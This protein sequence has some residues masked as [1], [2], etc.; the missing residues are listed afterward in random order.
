MDTSNYKTLNQTGRYENTTSEKYAVIPTARVLSLLADHGWSPTKVLE[1]RT[2]KPEKQGF[3]K[4]L[5]RLT[6]PSFGNERLDVRDSRPELILTN[7]YDGLAA[8]HLT[9]G[10]FEK[11]CANGLIVSK[12]TLNDQV[13]RHVGFTDD[14]VA[15]AVENAVG[16]FDLAYRERNYM[17]EIR[18]DDEEQNNFARMAAEIRYPGQG[19]KV[20]RDSLL[21]RR[22]YQQYEP[23]LWN[24]FN[25]V[26][27]N[28]MRG[29]ARIHVESLGLR[30]TTR[31]TS[32]AEDVRLNQGLWDLAINYGAY[33]SER[34]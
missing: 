6:N 33:L 1:A 2:V 29:Y 30:K 17:K 19:D 15:Q 16:R 22:H 18:L 3:Q 32:P 21:A 23:T 31:I 12:S 13:I 26:Q 34:F 5:V 7:S 20:S 8:F 10:L 27:E 11:V 4:H 14:K 9:I 25:A 24:T 28:F